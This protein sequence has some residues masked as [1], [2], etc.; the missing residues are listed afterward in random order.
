MADNF[1]EVNKIDVDKVQVGLRILADQID[2]E[3]Q[4]I[5]TESAD[6]AAEYLRQESPVGQTGNLHR[7]WLSTIATPTRGDGG[8]F[9]GGGWEARARIT[10]GSYAKPMVTFTKSGNFEEPT[11]PPIEYALA[12]SEGRRALTPSSVNHRSWT[13]GSG[14]WFAWNRGNPR[15]TFAKELRSRPGTHFIERAQELTDLWVAAR[16]RSFLSRISRSTPASRARRRSD[17]GFPGT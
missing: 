5:V 10:P 13:K 4:L 11:D 8:R 7:A 1:I 15:A 16:T 9:S 12:V 14:N 17:L 2:A 6:K 3:S